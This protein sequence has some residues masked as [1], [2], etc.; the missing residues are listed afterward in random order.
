MVPSG[1]H[2]IV[3]AGP[4]GASKST[5]AP[6]L[7]RDTLEEPVVRRRY[8]AGLENLFRLYFP[9]ANSWQLFDNSNAPS[10]R[11]VAASDGAEIRMFAQ[12]EVWR[13]LKEAFGG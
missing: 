11:L 9:L 4:N 6:D 13:T 12:A 2:V 10:P 7:L 8:R 5:A 1:P 3:V